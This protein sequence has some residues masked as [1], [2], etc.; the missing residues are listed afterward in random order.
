MQ[1]IILLASLFIYQVLSPNG[2][3]SLQETKNIQKN[4]EIVILTYNVRNCRGQDNRIDYQRVADIIN[5]INP[6]VV[7]L[8]ELDS[9]TLRSGKIIVLDE[10]ALRTRLFPTFGASIAYQGG[11]YGIGILSKEKP[12]WWKSIALPGREEIRSLLII[13]FKDFLFCSTHFSLNEEDRLKSVEIIN[14]HFSKYSKPVFLAGDLNAVPES[15]VIKN[16]ETKW[17][18]LNNPAD[19]TIPADNPN[20]C[21]DYIFVLKNNKNYFSVGQSTVEKE[22]VASDH[23]P[24]WVKIRIDK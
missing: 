21:I 24:V 4:N 3:F 19:P 23:L 12:I 13:E 1:R 16:I 18:M 5:R 7:A 11:K 20:R 14:D 17:Q 10:L 22:P 15:N 2:A 9:S 6:E 8:Q